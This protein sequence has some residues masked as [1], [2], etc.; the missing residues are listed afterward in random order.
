MLTL[1]GSRPQGM[2]A[3]EIVVELGVEKSIVSRILASLQRDGYVTRDPVT[4]LFRLGLKFVAIAFRYIESLGVYDICMPELG[5]LA[6]ETGEL[7]QLAVVDRDGMTYVA[8][9]EG[10]QRIR[11]FSQLGREAVLHAST[12]GKIWL[13]SLPEDA[14]LAVAL[15]AGLAPLAKNTIRSVDALR[16]ELA[17]VRSQGFALLDE[18]LFD[19]G[20]AVGVPIKDQRFGTVLGAIVL[21]GPTFRLPRERLVGIVPMLTAAADRL[22]AVWP[23]DL[24]AGCSVA[25]AAVVRSARGR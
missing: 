19:G 18:E 1:L 17:K 12:V 6:D 16:E 21:A 20:S 7:V 23:P 22:T 25:T 8:K 4:D 13:A 11:V 3:S 24:A 15:K 5:R 9:A 14:A 10:N 2:T